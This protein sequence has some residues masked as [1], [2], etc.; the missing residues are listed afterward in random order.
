MATVRMPISLQVRATRTAIS[1]RLAIRIFR[2]L[3]AAHPTRS[4]ITGAGGELGSVRAETQ[5]VHRLP[6]E[7]D[8]VVQVRA[9][10]QAAAAGSRDH[11]SALDVLAVAH[12]ESFVVAIGGDH[13]PPV[14][15]DEDPAV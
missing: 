6:G 3:T 7:I 9:G 13:T 12:Q 11:L 4:S 15:E 5:R 8:L 10:R 2:M 14:I 1:P